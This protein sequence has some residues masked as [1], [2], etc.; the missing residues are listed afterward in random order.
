MV[1]RVSKVGFVGSAPTTA[2][3]SAVSAVCCALRSHFSRV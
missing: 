2:S 1:S 3:H